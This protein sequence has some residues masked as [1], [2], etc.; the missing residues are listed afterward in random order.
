VDGL[1]LDISR[2]KIHLSILSQIDPRLTAHS[3]KR[4]AVT[5]L[6]DKGAPLEL[7]SRLAKHAQNGQAF[8]GTTLAYAASAPRLALMLL[9]QEVTRIL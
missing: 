3:I 5:H 8:S 9:T 4:G 2:R 7:I 6:V 1:A